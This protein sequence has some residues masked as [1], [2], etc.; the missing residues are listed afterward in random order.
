MRR[1]LAPYVL[2][3]VVLVCR[4]VHAQTSLQV[5]A[6]GAELNALAGE[7]IG[8]VSDRSARLDFEQL[9]LKVVS[10]YKVSPIH[11]ASTDR[12]AVA[13][14]RVQESRARFLPQMSVSAYRGRD[15]VDTTTSNPDNSTQTVTL[16]QFIYDFGSTLRDHDAF[17]LE[18]QSAEL[19]HYVDGSELMLRLVSAYFEV[20]RSAKQMEISK[21]FITS[22][23]QFLDLI[24]QREAIGGSSRADI[25]RAEAKLAEAFDDLPS[26]IQR[27]TSSGHRYSELFQSAPPRADIHER[28]AFDIDGIKKDLRAVGRDTPAVKRAQ[29][30]VK[31]A[32]D[33]LEAERMRRYGQ[34]DLQASYSQGNAQTELNSRETSARLQYSV[35]V[36]SGFS[37]ESRISQ[38]ALRLSEAQEKLLSI[39]NE[40]ERILKDALL[41]VGTLDDLVDSRVGLVR[42][43]K[44]ASDITRELFILNRGS[45]ADIFKAQE[46]YISATRNLLDA[47]VDRTIAFYELLHAVNALPRV[48]GESY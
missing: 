44:S 38:S 19:Q 4:D 29:L 14:A 20:Y 39:E 42:R 15:L 40:Q 35:N 16:T 7:L 8:K 37:Q 26:A 24:K 27:S 11:K 22:R 36:F 34:V 18:R 5:D 1:Q 3:I 17:E 25:V 23:E 46:D 10:A 13:G 21:S 9:R 43:A 47:V 30:D 45:I 6:I 12:S 2:A 28:P 31:V 32:E 41:K 48:M 33:R